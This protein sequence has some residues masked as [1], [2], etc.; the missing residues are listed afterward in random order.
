MADTKNPL[1]AHNLQYDIQ[2]SED[3]ISVGQATESEKSSISSNQDDAEYEVG[4]SLHP[5]RKEWM[6]KDSRFPEIL[7]GN[8][9]KRET[10]IEFKRSDTADEEKTED[11]EI[12]PA[13]LLGSAPLAVALEDP[14]Y[15]L[16]AS[17]VHEEA[18]IHHSDEHLQEESQQPIELLDQQDG[19]QDVM[20]LSDNEQGCEEEDEREKIMPK[21]IRHIV[22]F[23]I[24]AL[25]K[26]VEDDK[27][28]CCCNCDHDCTTS[29]LNTCCLPCNNPFRKSQ[30]A[31]V[32]IEEEFHI[33][34]ETLRKG[35]EAG[36][37][38]F[39]EIIFP[40][41]RPFTRDFIAISE[42]L[43]GLIG[44]IL[45]IV[46]FSLG[47]NAVYNILHLALAILSTLLGFTDMI[48]SLKFSAAFAKVIKKLRNCT[49]GQ[50]GNDT[51]ANQNQK[52]EC[53]KEPSFLKK[54]LGHRSYSRF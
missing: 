27:C 40:L 32:A 21:E 43:V 52:D 11:V 22:S 12:K 42:F 29:C 14:Q 35:S 53:P 51:E 19:T 10:I 50:M 17:E 9:G 48:V 34:N 31:H 44:L 20:S 15:Q 54:R 36:R 18:P 33:F 7:T 24:P 8:T 28:C 38:I 1:S 6:Q 37:A 47:S 30:D 16:Q 39:Q 45:S 41:I 5:M 26:V 49:L 3:G 23:V 13:D 46:S 4:D 25:L 2:D